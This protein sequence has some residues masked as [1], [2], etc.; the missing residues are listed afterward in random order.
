MRALR[1]TGIIIGIIMMGMALIAM[2]AALTHAEEETKYA[3]TIDQTDTTDG[4]V[5]FCVERC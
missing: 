5:F 1:R 3:V 2:S 4:S